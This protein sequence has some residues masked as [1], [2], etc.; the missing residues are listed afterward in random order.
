VYKPCRTHVVVDALSRL[1][2]IIK[3]TSAPDQTTD[4]SLF[5]I[6][7]KWLNDVRQFL[8][9]RQI[10]GTLSMLQKQRLVKRAEP[11]TLKNGEL[12]KMGQDIILRQC[13]TTTKAQ[14][15]MKELHEGPLGRHFATEIM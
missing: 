9:T 11:F 3:D 5:Y 15:L 14:M 6:K 1:S 13:L 8:K 10:E 2:N 7:P 4:A 12:Y